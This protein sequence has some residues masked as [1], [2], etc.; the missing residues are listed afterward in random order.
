LGLTSDR[1]FAVGLRGYCDAGRHVVS[2]FQ[3]MTSVTDG[4]RPWAS[5]TGWTGGHVPPINFF[6]WFC[7]RY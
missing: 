7:R 4:G 1:D 2:K 5:I 6:A 3:N